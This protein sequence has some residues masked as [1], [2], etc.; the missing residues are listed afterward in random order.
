MAV[1]G[2]PRL[3]DPHALPFLLGVCDAIERFTAAAV[4]RDADVFRPRGVDLRYVVERHLYFSMVNNTDLYRLFVASAQQTSWRPDRLPLMTEQFAPFLVPH[5]RPRGH[6]RRRLLGMW[7]PPGWEE[8]RRHFRTLGGSELQKGS[9]AGGRGILLFPVVQTKFV[10][11]LRPIAEAS[12]RPY[13]FVSFEDPDVYGYLG[14]RHLPRL[15]ITL[16]EPSRELLKVE[17]FGLLEFYTTYMNAICSALEEIR[18]ACIVVPEGNAPLNE[19]FNRAGHKL[20]IPTIC[21]QQG[22]SPIVHSGFRNM[23]YDRMCVW[24]K[25]FAEALSPSNPRQK[26]SITGNHMVSP[27]PR[28]SARRGGAIAFF[29]Q[30]GGSPLITREAAQALLALAAWAANQFPDRE[31]R[32]REHPSAPLTDAAA[33]ASIANVRLMP[34]AAA[35]LEQ[36]LKGSDI[37]VSIFSTTI[38]EAA[39]AGV[40]PLIVNVAGLPHFHPDIAREGAAMEV[41]DFDSARQALMRLANEPDLADAIGRGLDRIA[42]RYFAQDKEAAKA[43]IVAEIEAVA[44]GIPSQK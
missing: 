14:E 40:I 16:D 27:I 7:R 17:T 18:P 2:D 39:A 13:A 41:K 25:G 9:W 26:F 30:A 1:T 29:L 10:E 22:W 35:P 20:S 6:W 32:V 12:G 37:A 4:A 43:A 36:V 11:F 3:I 5:W 33:F 19:L 15:L 24:G 31:I 38:L 21:V 23:S 28:T 8:K 44:T 34:A 42:N